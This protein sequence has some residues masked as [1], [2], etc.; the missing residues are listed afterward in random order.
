MRTWWYYWR[1]HNLLMDP[2]IPWNRQIVVYTGKRIN[3]MYAV[4]DY[5]GLRQMANLLAGEA[6]RKSS[7]LFDNERI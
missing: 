6:K 3:L 4:R 5:K 2:T 7:P 1:I